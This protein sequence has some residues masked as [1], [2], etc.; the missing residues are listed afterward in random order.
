M[1]LTFPEELVVG[2]T[3]VDDQHRAFYRSLNA[4]HDAMRV[5]DLAEVHRLVDFL[6][7][8]A[9]DHFAAEERLMIEAG[10]PGY[11]DHMARHGEFTRDLRKWR[12][13][14]TEQGPTAGFVVDLSSWLTAWLR[15][16]IRRVDR[17][18]ARF[19]RERSAR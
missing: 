1:P 18:M 5:H 3:A 4:L 14:L 19:L 11:P 15:D 9:Q 7:T 12:T 17:E 10:Y 6:G 13:R 2:I 8:Y 16:H